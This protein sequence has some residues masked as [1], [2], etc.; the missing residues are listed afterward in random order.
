MQRPGIISLAQL[1]LNLVEPFYYSSTNI[2]ALSIYRVSIP[3]L[4][5][6]ITAICVYFAKQKKLDAD[7]ASSSYLLMIFVIVPICFAFVASWIL[8]YS[9]WGTRHLVIVFVPLSVFVAK[10][11]VNLPNLKIETFA[12]TMLFLLIGY[13]F[14]LQSQRPVSVPIWCGFETV[15]REMTNRQDV[16][17]VVFE[18]L[19]AYHLWFAF[20]KDGKPQ[21]IVKVKDLSGMTED[22]AYFLPRGFDRVQRVTFGGAFPPLMWL[23]FRSSDWNGYAPPISTFEHRGYQVVGQ[24]MYESGGQKDI[25]C[26][27]VRSRSSGC[28]NYARG[29]DGK[30][31]W[32]LQKS[33][34]SRPV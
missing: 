3:L 28:T 30:P 19:A 7:N 14:L 8:P 12:L 11:I 1:A 9:I 25:C 27:N 33:Y 18:D 15:G 23:V 20:R 22:P 31:R 4:L 5:I 10:A 17:I 34:R 6:A 32:K 21:K 24:K 26:R 29:G 16:P 2:D 13:A